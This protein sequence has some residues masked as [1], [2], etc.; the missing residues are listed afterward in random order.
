MRHA[1]RIERMIV[2][3]WMAILTINAAAQATG[4]LRLLMEPAGTTS[5]LLD[6]KHRMTQRDVSLLEGPHRFVFWAPERRMLD[7]TIIVLGGG[8]RDVRISLRYSEE[9]IEHLSRMKSYTSM[10]RWGRV[11]PPIVAGAAG[12]WALVSY[13]DYSAA[14]K[15]L[16]DLEDAY[17]TSSDPAGI[18]RLKDVEIPSAKDDFQK[19]RT[20]TYVATGLFVVSAGAAYYLRRKTSAMKAPVFEDK[21][22]VRFEGLAWTPD[23][24]GGGSWTAA[25]TIPIR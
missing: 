22:K 18:S 14:H 21:E 1:L 5:Y 11:V 3:G 17:R 13:L 16:V 7:T 19:A 9:Y 20:Q 15:D 12:A 23:V 10:Q 2:V 25:L 8:I 6:G 24:R 4:Q